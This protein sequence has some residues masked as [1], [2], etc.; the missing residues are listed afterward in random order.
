MRIGLTY[1]LAPP[2]DTGDRYEE[3]D[4]IETIESLEAALRRV[5]HDPVRLGWGPAM[6]EAM[7][8]QPVDAVFNI[9]EGI[10]GRGRES[11][12]PAVLEL[13]GIPCTGSSFL[14][15]GLTLDNALAKLTAKA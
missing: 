14:S 1:N 5:G 9:A 3:F 7:R 12:V 13:L 15:I 10:G 2:G 4:S 6:V 11:Q 8:R